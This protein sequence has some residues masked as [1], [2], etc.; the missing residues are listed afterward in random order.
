MDERV[1][2]RDKAY[3][4]GR[5]WG[6]GTGNRKRQG[7]KKGKVV[8]SSKKEVKMFEMAQFNVFTPDV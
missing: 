7:G 6:Y 3:R 8:P 4:W 1:V 5:I 2:H